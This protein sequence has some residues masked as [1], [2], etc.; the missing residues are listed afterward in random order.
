MK[1]LSS[2]TEL[3]TTEIVVPTDRLRVTSEAKVAALMRLI[4][5]GI[6]LG[7][8]T[9][10]RSGKEIILIDGAHRLEAMRRLGRSIIRADVLDCNASDARRL[11][12][13][14]NITAGMTPLQDAI[15]L[16]MYQEEYEKLHPETRRGVAGGLA[17]QGQQHANLPFA[18]LVSETRQ[19]SPGQVRKVIAAGRVLS[20]DERERLQTVPHRIAINEIVKLGKIGD[21]AIRAKAVA[22]LADG[23]SV[24]AAVRAVGDED[25]KLPAKD[26][27]EEG[28]QALMKAWERAPMAAKKRFLLEHAKDIWEA[29]NKGAPLANWSEAAE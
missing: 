15:F 22:A 14:G 21:S 18:E 5:E 17:R 6:F 8:I 27:V 25:G 12:I 7:A 4:G 26:P 3:N 13:S 23:K 9:V 11:E 19:I 28:F 1:L 24:A 16:G 2:I 10:R 29:Q 20:R